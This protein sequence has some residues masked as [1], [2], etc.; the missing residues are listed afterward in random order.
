MSSKISDLT[1]GNLGRN[2]FVP[3][4]RA[5]ANYKLN[6]SGAISDYV[7]S[8]SSLSGNLTD[9]NKIA[10]YGTFGILRASSFGTLNGGWYTVLGANYSSTIGENPVAPLTENRD[11]YLPDENG[12]FATREYIQTNVLTTQGYA[13]NTGAYVYNTGSLNLTNSYNGKIIISNNTGSIIY[14]INSG[15]SQGF[16]CQVLQNST[17]S[18]TFTGAA[19]VTLNSYGGLTQ[20]AGRYGSAAVQYTA[21]ESYV[22]A[23]NL[24]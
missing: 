10:M 15:L 5:G 24:A 9:S 18:I 20:I 7:S 17:G 1:S 3:I 4:S 12:T 22:L 16:S 8:N 13:Y 21:S 11:H 2:D 23:G 6:L 19:G 14:T